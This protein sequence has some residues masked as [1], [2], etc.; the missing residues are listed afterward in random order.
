MRVNEET[1]LAMKR[2]LETK[3]AFARAKSKTFKDFNDKFLS[4]SLVGVDLDKAFRTWDKVH[5]EKM[6]AWDDIHNNIDVFAELGVYFSLRDQIEGSYDLE[7][8]HIH[9]CGTVEI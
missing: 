9:F 6:D 4:S 1:V 8:A 3:L 2:M 5:E 7:K